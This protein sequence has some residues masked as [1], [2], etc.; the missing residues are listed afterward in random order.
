MAVSSD[1]EPI[2]PRLAIMARVSARLV[3]FEADELDLDRASDELI[4]V[5]EWT[6]WRACE[7]ADVAAR[8]RPVDPGLESARRLLD[9]DV[10]LERAWNELNH[11]SGRAAAN[12]V[13]ALAFSIRQDPEKALDR[14]DN[15]RRLAQLSESQLRDLVDRVHAAAEQARDLIRKWTEVH[16][17]EIRF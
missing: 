11:T 6:W 16:E 10:S 8:K 17:R 15:L 12:T 14:P 1:A 5:H 3:L 9:D 7:R 13:E 2:D 4:D